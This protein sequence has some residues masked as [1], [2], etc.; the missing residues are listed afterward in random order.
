LSKCFD[1]VGGE[2][3]GLW[4][5]DG[6]GVKMRWIDVSECFDIMYHVLCAYLV[7]IGGNVYSRISHSGR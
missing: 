7:T 3:A 2:L 6:S 1:S 5:N 4:Q